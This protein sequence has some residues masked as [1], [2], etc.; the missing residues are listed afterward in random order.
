MVVVGSAQGGVSRM[1]FR[2]PLTPGSALDQIQAWNLRVKSYSA[3]HKAM[4][5]S[6]PCITF[7]HL[8]LQMVDMETDTNQGYLCTWQQCHA[9]TVAAVDI[10]AEKQQVSLS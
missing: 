8:C 9:G 1:R 10:S 7:M 5:T 4:Q 2:V 6:H 3:L